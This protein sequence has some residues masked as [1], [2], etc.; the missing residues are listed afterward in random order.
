MCKV[1]KKNLLILSAVLIVAAL[2]GC[3]PLNKMMENADDINYSVNPEVLE[4]HGGEVAVN[5]TGRFPEKYFNKRVE[6]T[7]T[8]VL[9]Y[10]GGELALTP[11]FVQGE[12]VEGNAQVINYEPGG[13]FSYNDKF[14]FKDEMRISELEIRVEAR[15]RNK[16]LDFEPEV[17]AK[18]I[19][20][21]PTLVNEAAK[22]AFAKDKFVKDI[23]DSKDAAIF[24][25]KDRWNIRPAETRA[26][27]IKALSEYVEKATKDERKEMLNFMISAYASPEGEYDFNEKVS[28]GR[29]GSAK[30]FVNR[31]FRRIDEFKKEDFLK[32]EITVEDWEG[33]KKLVAESNLEDRDMILRVVQM[34]AD[35]A[36]REKEIRNMRATFK[37]LEEYIHPR[38]RRS[39]LTLNVMLIGNTDEEIKEIYKNNPKDLTL[40]EFLYLGTIT[41]DL[42]KKLEIYTKFTEVHPNEWRGFNNLG[43]TQFKLE[44]Y[45][46]AKVA[47]E[48]ARGIN[49]NAT[50]FNNL[51]II[52][53]LE[54]DL[55]NAKQHFTSATGIAEASHGQ[56]VINIIEG[57]YNTAVNFL[58]NDCSFNAGLAQLLAGNYSEAVKA[59]ECGDDKDNAINYYLKAIAGARQNNSDMLFNN[60]RTA[61]TKDPELKKLAKTDMEFYN[62]FD[63]NTF[64]TI[65]E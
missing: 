56:G 29:A 41:D 42:N 16:S 19:I 15:R 46:A 40:E 7:I 49:A 4:T 9:V 6:A 31:E 43:Y 48:K 39:E 30:T 64:K 55:T 10:E 37:E 35:P 62:Y 50:V 32:Q 1:M 59:A 51:G 22:P 52:A 13:R 58:S 45:D 44:N 8:P 20:A 24:F 54:N 60:L 27:D 61:V 53:L 14:N 3:N 28:G 65:V 2:T 11:I 47:F 21:T 25:E 26:E 33:F 57:D 18:G 38:L 23:P 63:N 34:H 36:E 17:I 12:K 5:I